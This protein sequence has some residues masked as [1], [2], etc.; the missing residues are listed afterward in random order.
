MRTGPSGTSSP[1]YQKI[2]AGVAPFACI[3]SA[4]NRQQ[5]YYEDTG[6]RGENKGI[7]EQLSWFSLVNKGKAF[8][9]LPLLQ[10][11]DYNSTGISGGCARDRLSP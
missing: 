8:I 10:R 6:A 1:A 2:R 9:A 7:D 5:S 3:L 4:G 11:S